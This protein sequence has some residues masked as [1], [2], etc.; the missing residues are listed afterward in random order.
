MARPSGELPKAHAQALD[1]YLR[2]KKRLAPE[3]TAESQSEADNWVEGHDSPSEWDTVPISGGRVQVWPKSEDPGR[4]LDRRENGRM[5]FLAEPDTKDSFREFLEG[6]GVKVDPRH[7]RD[8][9][10]S[11]PGDPFTLRVSSFN[12]KDDDPTDDDPAAKNIVQP[13]GESLDTVFMPGAAALVLAVDNPRVSVPLA[14][15]SRNSFLIDDVNRTE[16]NSGEGDQPD[17]QGTF[18]PAV[19]IWPASLVVFGDSDFVAN[20]FYERGSGKDLFLNSAN[21]LMG[22][23][24]L[25]SIRGK[26]LGLQGVQALTGMSENS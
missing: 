11:V 8:L 17:L 20:S 13:R 4:P 26:G 3:C 2:G 14:A 6:W 24:S 9:D 25:M 23:F 18:S 12:T 1:L 16:P 19:L 21:Y 7:I 22:D 10:R 15:T 5:I